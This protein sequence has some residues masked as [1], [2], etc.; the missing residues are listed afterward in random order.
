MGSEVARCCCRKRDTLGRFS[1]AGGNRSRELGND[2]LTYKLVDSI[3]QVTL[4]ENA[5]DFWVAL[6]FSQTVLS[7]WL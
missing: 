3:I 1:D 2:T 6:T 4:T 7:H 5:V